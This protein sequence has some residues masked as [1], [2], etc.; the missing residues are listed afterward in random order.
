MLRDKLFKIVLVWSRRG[1]RR[2]KR[3]REMGGRRVMGGEGIE[4]DEMVSE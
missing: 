2:L 4:N 3:R 1:I